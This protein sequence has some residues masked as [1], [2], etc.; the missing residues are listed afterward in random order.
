MEDWRSL[1]SAFDADEIP[2]DV[3]HDRFFL[4]WRGQF[5]GGDPPPAAIETL[6]F[7]VEAFCPDPGLRDPSQPWEADEAELHAA[8]RVALRRLDREPPP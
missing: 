2:A 3:F 1:L 8:V 7:V 6:F 5:N 4:L